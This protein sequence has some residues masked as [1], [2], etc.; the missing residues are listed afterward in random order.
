MLDPAKVLVFQAVIRH[1]SIS[2]AARALGWT[3][4]AVSQQMRALER[5]AGTPLLTRSAKGVTPTEAGRAL[6]GHAEV[7]IGHLEAATEVLSR[8]ASLERGTVRL[9]AFPSALATV[10][11]LLLDRLHVQHASGIELL[12]SENEPPEALDAVRTG[13]ADVA[14]TFAHAGL[15]Q[16]PAIPDDLRGV[17]AGADDVVVILPTDHTQAGRPTLELA[18]LAEDDW[19]AGCSRCRDHLLYQAHR[20]GFTPRICHQI[21]DYVTTQALVA[22]GLAVSLVPSSAL[23]AY[24]YPG[25]VSVATAHPMRRHFYAVHRSGADSIPAVRL[26]VRLLRESGL[27]S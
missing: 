11:P 16:I 20:A 12:L 14:L 25:V 18:D 21:D 10:V 7:I 4:P 6:L 24:R 1:G 22:R 15:T 8:F 13:Q 5:A 19:I 17:S 26:V 9:T 2:S 27:A 3:Q 23:Q